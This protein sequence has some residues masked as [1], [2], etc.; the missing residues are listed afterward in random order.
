MKKN[1][2]FIY[3]A[4]AIAVGVIVFLTIMH[5]GESTEFYGIAETREITLSS[6]NAVEINEIHVVPGQAVSNGELIVKLKNPALTMKINEISHMLEGLKAQDIVTT[7]SINSQIAELEARKTALLNEINYK[8]KKLQAQYAI[9]KQLSSGLKS[10]GN[11]PPT[12]IGNNTPN[13]IQLEIEGLEISR[14]L[15]IEPLKIKTNMLQRQLTS[16]EDP[17]TIRIAL[18]EKELNLLLEEKKK[19]FIYAQISGI[20]GSVRCKQGEQIAPFETILTLHAKSPSYIRGYVHEFAYSKVT[21]GIKAKVT[22]LA[23]RSNKLSGKVVGVG[24]RIIEYPLRLQKTPDVRVY[25]REVQIEIP[26]VNNFL[27]GEKV[28]ISVFDSGP[29]KVDTATLG[30]SMS[31]QH[32]EKV[33][34]P[35]PGKR[36]LPDITDITVDQTLKN[37]APVEASGILYLKDLKKYL[38]IS[39]TTKNESPVLYLMN[40]NGL[41]EDEITIQGAGQY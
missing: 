4:W 21:P 38:V 13:P 8:I 3:F 11:G 15:T 32:T 31:T 6:E 17:V 33:A 14:K 29:N 37:I 26:E 20:I 40:G 2:K 9:N 28:L 24:S 12:G 10:L 39:D 16:L 5:Q 41:I 22:S 35:V 34:G 30:F 27:L 18:L 23:D 1:I 25:G 36:K 7:E 19:L